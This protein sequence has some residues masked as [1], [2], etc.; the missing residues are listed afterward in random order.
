MQLQVF[1][2]EIAVLAIAYLLL[3]E[4]LQLSLCIAGA[5]RSRSAAKGRKLHDCGC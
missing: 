4:G 1:F 5:E 3:A 2:L